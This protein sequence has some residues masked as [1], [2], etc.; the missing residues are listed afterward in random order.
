MDSGKL[1]YFLRE[2]LVRHKGF[3]TMRVEDCGRYIKVTLNDET[4]DIKIWEEEKGV[5]KIWYRGE[6][7]YCS[8]MR[9]ARQKAQSHLLEEWDAAWKK[10]GERLAKWKYSGAGGAV[11]PEGVGQW[12]LEVREEGGMLRV[13]AGDTVTYCKEGEEAYMVARCYAMARFMGEYFDFMDAAQ[14]AKW[15]TA[16]EA[17]HAGKKKIKGGGKR[18]NLEEMI[19]NKYFEGEKTRSA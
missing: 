1:D 4:L 17:L 10:V 18:I 5:W 7:A 3:P 13:E 9:E 12:K 15:V 11:V 19:E 8:S 14:E 2:I 16:V 6:M